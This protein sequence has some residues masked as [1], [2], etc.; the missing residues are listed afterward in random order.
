MTEKRLDS[1]DLADRLAG[2]GVSPLARA[3][4]DLAASELALTASLET[5]AFLQSVLDSSRDCI[6]VLTLGGELIFMNDGGKE[7][8]EVDDF[9]AIRG[10]AWTGFWEGDDRSAAEA[11]LDAARSGFI[12]KFQGSASTARGTPKYWDV[13]VTRISGR[14][15]HEDRIL[16]ISRDITTAREI[17]AQKDLLSR[18]L[19]HRIKNSLAVVQAI[20]AQTFR[21]ADRSTLKEFNARLAAL[22]A[23]QGLLLQTAWERVS[24]R[25]LIE[26]TLAPIWASGR[27][28]L[29]IDDLEISG[30]KGLALALALHELGTNALKY[31]ALSNDEGSVGIELIR[32]A[33]GFQLTWREADGP[34]VTAPAYSGFGTR[35]ITRNL[36]ADFNGNVEL[37]FNPSGVVLTLSAPL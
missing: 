9:E 37:N 14:D 28:L 1:N 18:E 6:K 24:V 4:R 21:D 17:E 27:I 25:E 26:K 7:V 20:A 36:E 19:G 33:R 35:L 12:G 16:S 2:D 22:G 5:T 32:T 10:C 30:R 3:R 13:T 29:K 34:P 31:G 15:G 23:A 8:M 11:A